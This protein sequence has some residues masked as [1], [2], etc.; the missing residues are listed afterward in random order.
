MVKRDA[1]RKPAATG[2]LVPS[3]RDAVKVRR[4]RII[5]EDRKCVAH[6]SRTGEPCGNAA[7]KGQNVCRFHGGA[8]KA[9][10]S[11]AHERILGAADLGAR[12]LI[13]F[14]TSTKVPYNVR[15]QAARDLLDRAGLAA[16][17]KLDITAKWQDDIEAVMVVMEGGAADADEDVVDAELVDE[18]PSPVDGR[19]R[20]LPAA[21]AS[22]D[23]LFA[24]PADPAPVRGDHRPPKRGR[25]HRSRLDALAG[26]PPDPAG[27][28][29]AGR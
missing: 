25:K 12:Q 4:V 6:S 3:K 15:L 29:R 10:K 24:S 28:A 18:E 1:A 16:T 9:S 14:M 23:E 5:R 13:A 2:G 8:T 19:T 26:E 7:L 17:A 22:D 27:S 21:T 11:R 20:A